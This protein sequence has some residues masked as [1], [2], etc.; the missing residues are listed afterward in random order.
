MLWL[1]RSF[2]VLLYWRV[3]GHGFHSH[4]GHL[5]SYGLSH[6]VQKKG[7]LSLSKYF[8]A[9]HRFYFKRGTFNLEATWWSGG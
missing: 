1:Q 6:T 9:T 3:C 4:N 8:E 2:L 5:V 7:K